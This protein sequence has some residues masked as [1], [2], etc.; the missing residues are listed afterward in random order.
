MK[1]AKATLLI[2]VENQVRELDGKLL[3]ACVAVRRGLPSIVGYKQELESRIASFPRSIYLAK[4]LFRGNSKFL[5]LARKLGH[6]NVA[7]DEEALVHPPP[8]IYFARRLSPVAMEHVSHLFAWGRDNAEVWRQYPGLPA[9]TP[10]HVTGNP[11]GD[12][13][14][15]EMCGFYQKQVEK[16]LDSYGDFIL[17]EICFS[18]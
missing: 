17:T 2:P 10:I 15:P 9:N 6:E 18:R 13:L 3:L 16:I 12:L 4:S 8:E 1:T 11:R 7:W 5:G 14:R